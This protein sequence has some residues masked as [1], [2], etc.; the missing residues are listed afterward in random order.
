MTN[1]SLTNF[2]VGCWAG[3]YIGSIAFRAVAGTYQ[4]LLIF[5]LPGSRGAVQLGVSQ[6]ILPELNHLIKQLRGRSIPK[7]EAP[8]L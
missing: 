7:L 3:Y 5:S 1:F 2:N 8:E 6:L 4:I